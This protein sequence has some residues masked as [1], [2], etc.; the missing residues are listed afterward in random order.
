MLILRK[1]KPAFTL[2]E[3]SVSLFIIVILVSLVVI[4][5]NAGFSGANLINAQN[6]L[7]Q[8]IK[9]AQ[10]YSL[11]YRSYDDV[12][13]KYWGI[14]ISTSSPDFILFA[15]LNEN[16]VYDEGE[17]DPMLGGRVVN[18][19]VDTEFSYLTFD[20]SAISILFE[21]GTGR[22]SVYD[23]DSS[24]FDNNPWLVELKDK[25]IDI[26]RIIIITP[27]ADINT[28][29]CSCDDVELYCCSFCSPGSCVD[30]EE[31]L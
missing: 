31:G 29:N 13:P 26:A 11:S 22:M 16:A 7:F 25:R 5:Y 21:S 30:F 4:N 8:N 28:D 24:A 10:S 18:L 6:S 20:S 27:P 19:S 2:I 17:A 23:V 12:L 3:L 15:D 14:Y 1:I 9:L